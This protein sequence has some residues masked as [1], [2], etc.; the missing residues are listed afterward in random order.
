MHHVQPHIPTGMPVSQQTQTSIMV[1]EKES[2]AAGRTIALVVAC[3]TAAVAIIVMVSIFVKWQSL[4]DNHETDMAIAVEAGKLQQQHDDTLRYAELDKQP[5]QEFK[6]VPDS[7]G[8]L[9]FK[10]PKTWSA[11]VAN[12][13][14]NG[15]GF[16]AYFRPSEVLPT[17]DALSR[18]AVRL[19][20]KVEQYESVVSKYT[21]LAAKLKEGENPKELT[22]VGR[23]EKYN[24]D[25]MRF[26]G[27]LTEDGSIS[28]SVVLVKINNSTAIIQCDSE[29]YMDDFNALLDTLV[30]GSLL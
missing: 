28:G 10:Y 13:G 5:W 23:L 2:G 7:Y 18:Y 16:D 15:R 19:N 11:Y 22:S 9:Q 27:V 24:G 14:S 25:S 1:D 4:I 29:A 17:S 8:A 21:E 12:D 20:I 30:R 26:D 6:A 3:L